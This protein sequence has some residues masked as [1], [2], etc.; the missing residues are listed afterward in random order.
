MARPPRTYGPGFALARVGDA[1]EPRGSGSEQRA[2]QSPDHALTA[3]V[4]AASLDHTPLLP[5]ARRAGWSPG[6]AVAA[7]V[8]FAP[9]KPRVRV[10]TITLEEQCL[11]GPSSGSVTTRALGSSRPM[12]SPRMCSFTTPRLLVMGTARWPR[13]PGSRTRPN[14]APRARRRTARLC[15]VPKRNQAWPA[16]ASANVTRRP[17]CSSQ[18]FSLTARSPSQ[19]DRVGTLWKIGFSSWARRRL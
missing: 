17:R 4:G 8:V 5:W 6:T 18:S 13:E 19:S 7:L 11:L 2:R 14:R 1:V 3:S 10:T 9:R 12:T 15:S 16:R